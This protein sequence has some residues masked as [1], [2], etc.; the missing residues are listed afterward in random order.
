MSGEEGKGRMSREDR[1]WETEWE[2]GVSEEGVRGE[3]GE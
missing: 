1:E 2:G 3:E